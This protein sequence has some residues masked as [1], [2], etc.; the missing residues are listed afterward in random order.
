MN[1]KRVLTSMLAIATLLLGACGDDEKPA[2]KLQFAFGDETV[3]LKDASLFLDYE[4]FYNGHLYRDYYIT[5]AEGTYYIEF[6]IAV[7]EEE[8]IV[9]GE[10]PAYYNWSL[11][12]ATSNIGYLYA[13]GGDELE[14]VE[15]DLLEDA[16]GDD[17]IIVSGGV[18]D[19]ETMT[20]K[21]KSTIS[22]YHYD[23]STED[24]ITENVTGSL[25]FKGEIE[26]IRSAGVK[27]SQVVPGGAK[28]LQ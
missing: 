14:Y 20:V 5:D 4:G 12:S 21:F 15:L 6:E 26:D 13:E 28:H 23:A 17:N 7:P 1:I 24:W 3:S 25:Y 16:D 27:R 19:G 9:A 22:Y 10:Y 11:P 2:R 8:E 18:E